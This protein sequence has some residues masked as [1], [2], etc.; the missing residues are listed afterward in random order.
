MQSETFFP[1][2]VHKF[3]R[4][5]HCAAVQETVQVRGS[6][7]ECKMLLLDRPLLPLYCRCS[8][9]TSASVLIFYLEWVASAVVDRRLPP[10]HPQ[11]VD[12]E[13]G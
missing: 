7:A 1:L 4:G 8:I 11:L 6:P 13:K 12:R 3:C 2:N 5:L 9:F 10:D